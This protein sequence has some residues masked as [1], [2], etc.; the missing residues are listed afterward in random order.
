MEKN[1][2]ILGGGYGGLRVIQRLLAANLSDAI[3]LTLVERMPHH[4]LKTEYYALAAGTVSDADVRVD[5]PTDPRLTIIHGEVTDIDLKHKQIAIK[6]QEPLTYDYLV[7]GLGSVDKYHGVPGADEHT[8]SIQSINRTR[9]TYQVLNS[10]KTH[11]KV[12]IIGG[13]LSGV[14]LAA[15]LRE[16]RPDLTI[17]LYDRGESIL[18]PFP[19]RLRDF[20]SNWFYEHDVELIHKA[21]ITKVEPQRLYNHDQPIDVDVI[22][23]TAGIQPHP[24]VRALPVEKDEA[25]RIKLSEH[26][27]IPDFPEVFVVG[28]CASLPH[29]PSAQLAEAQGDQ[30]ALVIQAFLNNESLPTL[31]RI[32]L[33]GVLGSLGKKKGFG[34]MGET[35]LIGRVP[36]LLKTGVLWMYKYHSG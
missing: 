26:H 21:N 3:R 35:T 6:D 22:V 29:A 25:E 33:K 36:R 11:G 16:S 18:S 31:G 1:I 27:Y 10:L 7:I 32:K 8:L 19:K 2:I 4:C 20:V 5:F 17:Q 28:D 9:K 15:E 13:G 30:I 34:I 14:E 24:L 23:W 12:A